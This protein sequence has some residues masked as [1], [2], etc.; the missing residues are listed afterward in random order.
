MEIGHLILDR[1]LDATLKSYVEGDLTADEAKAQLV[2]A[3]TMAARGDSGVDAFMRA[4]L[5]A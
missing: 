2:H 1:F 4:C 3:I 5:D